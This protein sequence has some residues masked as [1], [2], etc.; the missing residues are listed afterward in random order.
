MLRA[1]IGS[2]GTIGSTLLDHMAFDRVFNSDDIGTLENY[3][4]D[5]IV[6]AA[7]SGNRLAINRGTT[8]DS[9]DVWSIITAI[10]RSCPRHVVLI[11]SVDAITAPKTYYGNNR[12]RL[13]YYLAESAPT[14][15]L[16]LST[17]IGTHIKKNVLHDIKHNLFL[18]KIDSG[19]QTQWCLLDDLSKLISEAQPQDVRNIVSEPIA[20]S[21]ILARY[22]P[23]FQALISTDSVRYNQQPYYYTRQEIF[24]AMDRYML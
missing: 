5:Q 16:R 12:A 8:A 2:Q 23:G 24:A 9:E 10:K 1:L 11:S 13:E 21:E 22:R 20:H 18:D 19:A 17:L 3:Q 14:S 15:I 6:V 7:P 4:F